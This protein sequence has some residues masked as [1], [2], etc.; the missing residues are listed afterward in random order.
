MNASLALLGRIGLSLVFIMSGWEKLGGYAATQGY[1]EAMGVSGALLPAVIALEFGGGL[2]IL[3]GLFSRT[4]SAGLAVFAVLAALLFHGNIADPTQ[5][6][7]FWKN[8]T[9]AGG[10]LMLAANGPG[11]LSFESWLERNRPL[12]DR[13]AA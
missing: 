9:I 4:A 6:L 3:A 12:P 1:M 7:L 8:I 2:A 13:A 5:S 11:A 10:M